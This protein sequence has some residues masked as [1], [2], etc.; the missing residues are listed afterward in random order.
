ME[1]LLAMLNSLP[2]E[3]LPFGAAIAFWLRMEQRLSRVE[4]TLTNLPCKPAPKCPTDE[5]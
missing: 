5:T 1:T 2:P 4:R 3:A